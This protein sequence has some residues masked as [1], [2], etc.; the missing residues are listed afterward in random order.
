M[1]WSCCLLFDF[2]SRLEND[3]VLKTKVTKSAALLR[4][5]KNGRIKAGV[6]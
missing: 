6:S 3:I 5:G 4:G 1:F 2:K